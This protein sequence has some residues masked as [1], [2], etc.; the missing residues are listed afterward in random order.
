MSLVILIPSDQRLYRVD[1]TKGSWQ[2]FNDVHFPP[3]YADYTIVQSLWPF[4]LFRFKPYMRWQFHIY[5][6]TLRHQSLHPEARKKPPL[7]PFLVYRLFRT[8]L[9]VWAQDAGLGGDELPVNHLPPGLGVGHLAARAALADAPVE[10]PR[11]LPGV[12][13]QQGLELDAAGGQ[14]TG[15]LLVG[16]D[17]VAEVRAG[18]T[19][20]AER[21]HVD[22]LGAP[23]GARVRRA[24]EVGG[25]QAVVA[26]PGADEPDEAGAEHGGRSKDELAAEGLHGREGGLEL[27][28]QDVGDRGR[29]RGD[30]VEEEVVV[31]GH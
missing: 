5:T 1:Y 25:Q 26:G 18:G 29:L 10:Q 4:F 20:V 28:A 7:P 19:A 6:G 3:V 21:V 31:V 23:V 16:E 9:E 24:G 8:L 22:R 2:P 14:L 30:A 17:L 15:A 27:L 13:A 12:E 11:V